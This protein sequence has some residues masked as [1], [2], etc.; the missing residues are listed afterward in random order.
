MGVT[1]IMMEMM[2]VTVMIMMLM[3]KM[4]VNVMGFV[5]HQMMKN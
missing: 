1:M 4:T 2:T 5:Q 3:K